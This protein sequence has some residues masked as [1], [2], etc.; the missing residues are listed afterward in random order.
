MHH[1]LSRIT[2]YGSIHVSNTEV[3]PGLYN[4]HSLL[5]CQSGYSKISQSLVPIPGL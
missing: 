4:S 5:D 2:G 1:I 3:H